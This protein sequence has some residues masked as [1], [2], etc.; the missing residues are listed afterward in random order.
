MKTIVSIVSLIYIHL[1][2]SVSP[3]PTH[4]NM[5]LTIEHYIQLNELVLLN[6]K[7]QIV[8]MSDC[9]RHHHHY[10]HFEPYGIDCL[11]FFVLFD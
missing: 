1:S 9:R 6:T 8:S 7:Q 5:R 3:S 2:A 11:T 4:N 10:P